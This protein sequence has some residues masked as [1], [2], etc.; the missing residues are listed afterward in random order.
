MKDV[1]G[2]LLYWTPRILGILF[3][4]FISLFA[5]DVFGAGYSAGELVVALLM[6]LIPTGLVVVALVIAWR[7]EWLGAILFAALGLWY[8]ILAWGDMHWSA[9]LFITGPLLLIAALFLIDWRHRRNLA[10]AA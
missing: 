8:I 6:H 2:R 4:A 5:L 10:A 9:Y 3:A 1:R 7:W